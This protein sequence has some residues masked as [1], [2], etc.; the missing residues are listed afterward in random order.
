[1]T[2]AASLSKIPIRVRLTAAFALAMII[3]LVGAALVVYLRLR[4]E[5]DDAINA[6]LR[7]QATSVLK[8]RPD[9]SSMA[10]PDP[11]ERFVQVLDGDRAVVAAAGDARAPA[12]PVSAFGSALR[13]PLRVE[14]EVAGIDGRVRMLAQPV[15]GPRVRVLVV[16][17]SLNDRN[18]ALRGVLV[19]FGV[20][21]TAAVLLASGVGYLLARAGLAPV[22]AIRARAVRVSLTDGDPLPLPAAQDEVHALAVTL[23]Q[24]LTQLRE[25]F[26]RERRFVADASHELRTPI[27]VIR[28]EIEA[29]LNSP[30]CRG[31]A[32]HS[33]IAALEECDQLTQ[34]ADDLL[35]LARLSD[36][37]VPVRP[38]PVDAMSLLQ[39]VRDRFGHRAAA[40]GR[41][42]AIDVAGQKAF[43]ADPD[44]LRQA[45]SNLVDNALRHGT[46]T[47][48]LRYRQDRG[49]V[50]LQV[51]DQ[52]P[53]FPSDLDSRAFEPFTRAQH[54][55]AGTGS[56]LGLAI[57]AAIARAHDGTAQR[58][59]DPA[60]SG[61]TIELC[62]PLETAVRS[63]I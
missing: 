31:S 62:L 38:Q 26:E 7:A 10:L 53:G 19:S 60:S 49:P 63:P 25:A 8:G 3:M 5:L 20:G 1:M 27:T 55:R 11:D 51:S 54:T 35:V 24:M 18:D 32:R 46:G 28:V 57:V 36:T 23:N 40:N 21:G 39:G 44:R 43:S 52:G 16:G 22:E 29:A 9:I 59:D 13:K 30:E 41:T 14:T 33:L 48:T 34:L 45:L 12:V 42:I 4:A 17:Q 56:G 58:V 47:I 6:E 15:P 37:G 50:S 2:G 61:T